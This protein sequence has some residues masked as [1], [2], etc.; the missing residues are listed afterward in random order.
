MISKQDILDRATEWRLRPDVEVLKEFGEV[1]TR[2]AAN[3][4]PFFPRLGHVSR[5]ET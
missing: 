5:K 4:P 1:Y 3:T 2:Y